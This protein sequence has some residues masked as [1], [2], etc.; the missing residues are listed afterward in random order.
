[1]Q[2]EFPSRP[3]GTENDIRRRRLEREP[4]KGAVAQIKNLADG[5]SLARE[6]P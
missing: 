6:L 4:T 5:T 3:L 2:S 1:M